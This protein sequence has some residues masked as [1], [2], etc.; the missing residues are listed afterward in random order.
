MSARGRKRRGAEAV[1]VADF[2]F[3][4]TPPSAITPI[5]ECP[6]LTLPG[7]LWLDPCAGTGR[8]PLTVNAHRSDVVWLMAEIDERHAP[9][10]AAA[11][12]PVDTLLPFGNFLTMAWPHP[13][14]ELMIM[15]PPFSLALDFV[16]AGFDRAA[17]V[18]M[19]QRLNW[20]APARS[21][22]LRNYMPDV[23]SLPTRPSF[24]G[25]GST[26][27]AEYAWFH[28]PVSGER[29]RYGRAQMLDD[30]MQR[31]MFQDFNPRPRRE[32]Q[33]PQEQPSLFSQIG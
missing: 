18:L 11:V 4:P 7:G 33:Q 16:R 2:E 13:L 29:R 8:I 15:N 31:V 1:A 6:D 23:Y 25:D 22:W 12:R 30:P 28:W 19:L 20:L 24:T 10:L 17:S 26:D 3:Y 5:I 9:H 27:A 14:A 21:S 32:T